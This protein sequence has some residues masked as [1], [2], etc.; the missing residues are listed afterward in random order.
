MEGVLKVSSI[1]LRFF[2]GFML[3]CWAL[4][5]PE[6]ESHPST[7]IHMSLTS[8]VISYALTSIFECFHLFSTLA[9]NIQEEPY[10]FSFWKE[11]RIVL[12]PQ[13]A[14]I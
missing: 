14:E 13:P 2:L 7:D 10:C 9:L 11:S 1:N 4:H 12:H 5:C 8:R 6:E 3:L